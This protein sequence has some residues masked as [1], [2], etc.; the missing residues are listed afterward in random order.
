[1][2]DAVH[3]INTP[4]AYSENLY[5][6]AS[7]STSPPARPAGHPTAGAQR[8]AEVKQLRKPET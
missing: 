2:K 3:R 4:L 6:F 5:V 8:R 1:M 7:T